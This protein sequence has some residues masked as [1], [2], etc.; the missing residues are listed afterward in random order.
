MNKT[1]D[2]NFRKFLFV[3]SVCLPFQLFSQ[4]KT[5]PLVEEIKTLQTIVDGDFMKLPVIDLQ[6]QNEL[7]ISFDY[8]ADE[9]PWLSYR[10][11]HCDA[12]WKQDNLSEMD[13]V[14][15][16]FPVKI[17]DVK[18]SF[19]T[20]T[21]Y[22]HHKIKFP[23]EDVQL[24]VSGN[25]AV[26]IFDQDADTDIEDAL[27]VATFS[28]SEQMVFARGEVTANTDI[29]FHATHQQLNLEVAWSDNR[30]PYLDPMNE[31]RV[32]VRQNRREETK[33]EVKMPTRLESGKAIYE[34]N[35][36]LIFDAGNCYRRFEFVDDRYASIG[37]ESIRYK[38]P[39]YIAN[40][41]PDTPRKG[42]NFRFDKTQFGRYLIRAARVSD[43]DTEADYFVANFRLENKGLKPSSVIFLTGDF[44]S[45]NGSVNLQMDFL[46]EEN[47][48]VK[49]LVLKQ[50]AYNYQYVIDGNPSPIEGDF[51]ETENEYEI[52]IYYR[53]NGARYDRLMGVATIE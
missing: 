16:F 44:S 28:V 22:Y 7:E 50:G 5:Q 37:V 52:Y 11:L 42:E 31:L 40:L 2:M 51:Y 32:L 43:V 24:K 4:Y 34:H 1:K 21:S 48:F 10:V 27:A 18:P 19:N 53:P 33:R 26:L 41:W 9:Q 35:R 17:E 36:D 15:G 20:F 14:E 47:A 45:G 38:A 23:N 29:D 49:S 13:Y 30:L 8:L 25:Y 12:D 39:Y 3:V 46:D 6:G